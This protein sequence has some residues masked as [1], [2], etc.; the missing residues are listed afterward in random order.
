MCHL[1]YVPGLDTGNVSCPLGGERLYCFL[2]GLNA[3]CELCECT[4]CGEVV[5]KYDVYESEQKSR[6]GSGSNEVVFTGKLCRLGFSWIDN[7]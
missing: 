6:V 7:H 2:N 3:V 1:F 5:S 4:K